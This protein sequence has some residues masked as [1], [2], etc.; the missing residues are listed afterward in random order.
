[1]RFELKPCA[2]RF[3]EEA[4]LPS[5]VVGP[6]DFAPL[7]RD[8]IYWSSDDIVWSR[9]YLWT[10][11]W[12]GLGLLTG[13]IVYF[14]LV[15]GENKVVRLV[16]GFCEKQKPLPCGRGS[17]RRV[18]S[19]T[20]EALQGIRA[21]RSLLM[22]MIL[23]FGSIYLIRGRAFPPHGN[24]LVYSIAVSWLISI[25]IAFVTS[26]IFFRV[27]PGLFF[28]GNW[29]KHGEIYDRAG[30]RAFRWVLFHSPLG[31]INPNFH[32]RG[33]RIDCDRLL[34]EI[35]SSEC[36]HWLTFAATVMLASSYFRHD[37]AVYGYVMLLVR[38]PFDLYPI[39]LL[40][41][42]RGRLWRVLERGGF[43]PL[44]YSRGSEG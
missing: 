40:R 8:A 33:S 23:T 39:M 6:W 20:P 10:G 37:Q 42:N 34:R 22:I 44:L 24:P 16:I 14:Q 19:R 29:E 15:T 38:I 7:V 28:V 36:I 21:M 3:W 31:W 35:N 43:L 2:R 32:L 41:W 5:S 17:E 11:D 30:V 4:C 9:A 26:A 1:M 27:R 12:C 13:R 25:T 18:M